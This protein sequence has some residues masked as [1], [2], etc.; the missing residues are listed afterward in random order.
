MSATSHLKNLYLQITA[1]Y[2]KQWRLIGNLLDLSTEVLDTIEHDHNSRDDLCYREML[3]K[4]LQTDI[5]AS[6][7]RILACLKSSVPFT[8]PDKG[9]SYLYC[10]YVNIYYYCSV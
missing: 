1:N 6:W 3:E 9:I 10:M 7:Q 5:N 2:A 4:W 8:T